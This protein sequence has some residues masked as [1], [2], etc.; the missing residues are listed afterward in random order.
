MDLISLLG[1]SQNSPYAGNPFLDIH[2]PEGLIDMSNTPMDLIGIDNK[3]N[4][5]K[6]KAGA[7]NPY[8]FEGNI[9]REI[10]AGNIYQKGGLTKDNIF[11]FLFE[12]DNVPETKSAKPE[13]ATAPSEDELPKQD[14]GQDALALEQ[15]NMDWG[16]E[17]YHN[18]ADAGV[19]NPYN[20]TSNGLEGYGKQFQN[21]DNKVVA[22]TQELL[23]KF[24][25]LRLTSG[26]RT[27]GDKDAHPLGRAIDL[28][29]DP[30]AYD[31]Y[32]NTIVPKY[33]FN[34]EL[35]PNHGTGPHIH[36]GY[37]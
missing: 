5:K 31:Y 22:A 29:Y 34:P 30:Q 24:P 1:Y 2:T 15:A 6:M 28:S 8:Q 33:G 12:D 37:Y 26:R 13:E 11:N 32:K 20:G 27:W 35:K 36:L 14:D 19:G 17:P 4:K 9:V 16:M 25:S 7:K 23:G 18:I 3:G 21:I 10:P